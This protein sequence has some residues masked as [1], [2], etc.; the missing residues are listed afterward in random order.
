[1]TTPTT[2]TTFHKVL[3]YMTSTALDG[4][5]NRSSA[6]ED[7][8]QWFKQ[9][10]QDFYSY[11]AHQIEENLRCIISVRDSYVTITVKAFDEDDRVV[12]SAS[13]TALKKS[14]SFAQVVAKKFGKEPATCP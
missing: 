6:S 1:M 13:G 10:D 4:K 11:A 7:V 3:V 8:T 12:A 2:P 14:H 5:S 9:S